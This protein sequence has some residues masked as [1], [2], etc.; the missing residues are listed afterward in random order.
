MI[1][2]GTVILIFYFPV[3]PSVC[4]VYALYLLY[5]LKS[6]DYVIFLIVI[7]FPLM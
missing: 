7:R 1:S 5:L 4:L 2:V 6:T 3:P